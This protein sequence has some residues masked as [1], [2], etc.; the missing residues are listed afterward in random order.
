MEKTV[1][2]KD[3]VGRTSK[4]CETKIS[5]KEQTYDS[6]KKVYIIDYIHT[7]IDNGTRTVC[8]LEE[9]VRA[10]NPFNERYYKQ[11]FDGEIIV[12][13]EMTDMMI[14]YLMMDDEELIKHIGRITPEYYRM[15]IMHN[16]H[17]LWD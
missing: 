15:K 8:A 14:K 7:Y 2:F 11:H 1:I 13:N 10:P 3:E 5:V 17:N 4:L 9:D 12:K 16:I 6:G